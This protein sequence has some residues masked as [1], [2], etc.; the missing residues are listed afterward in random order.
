MESEI[1]WDE[2]QKFFEKEYG[3]L[4]MSLTFE[5][6]SEGMAEIEMR[7]SGLMKLMSDLVVL[8]SSKE[9]TEEEQKIE[10]EIKC[11]FDEVMKFNAKE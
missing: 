5:Y 7:P 1:V 10:N 9:F 11:T 8:K 2:L 3:M 4:S 6:P